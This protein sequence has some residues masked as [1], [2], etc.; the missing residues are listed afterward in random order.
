MA[1]NTSN[2]DDRQ[3]DDRDARDD[4]LWDKSG[5]PD[6]EVAALEQALAGKRWSGRLPEVTDPHAPVALPDR[7]RRARRMPRLLVGGLAAAALV[8]LAALGLSILRGP[9][10]PEAARVA[11]VEPVE[12]AESVAP[13]APVAQDSATAYSVETLEGA[14]RIETGEA[15][16]TD[17]SGNPLDG[18][19]RPGARLVTDAG[20]RARVRVGGIGSVVVEPDTSLRVEDPS[21]ATT[22]AGADAGY[23]LWLERGTLRATIFAAPRLFQLGTPSGIAVDMGCEYTASVDGQGVTRLAVTLGQVSF[24]TPQRKVLVP[25]GASARAWPGRGPGT[26]VWDD[27]AP[28]FRAAVEWLDEAVAAAALQDGP[29]DGGAGGLAG[30]GREDLAVAMAAVLGTQRGQDSLSLWHLL[31]H[32]LDGRL[33]ESVY[34]H[35]ATLAPPPEGVGKDAVLARERDA[36]ERWKQALGWAWPAGLQ[37]KLRSERVPRVEP[38]APK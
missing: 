34:Q 12:P 15:A 9:S 32:E 19:L 17:A 5:P 6:P 1:M 14:P 38:L 30:T 7:D 25:A 26:P 18:A 24:E 13:V 33:R 36:L 35:L 27:A 28:E 16:V 29:E 10:G 22:E 20:A 21:A 8:A 2:D 11:Q 31:D 23:L 3:G 37:S 4:Y